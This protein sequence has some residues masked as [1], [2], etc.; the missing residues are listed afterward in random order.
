MLLLILWRLVTA[1]SIL[2]G[3]YML[4][5]GAVALFGFKK[6][7]AVPRTAPKTKFA[8]VVAARNE[9]AVIANLVHSLRRQNYPPELFDIIVAPNNCTDD[10][11]GAAQAAGATLYAPRGEIHS[12]GDVLREVVDHVV[13]AG[14]YDAMCVFDA[15]NL[16]HPDFLARMND[17]VCAGHVAVQGFRDSKNPEQSAISGCY[18]ICYWMLNRFYNSARSALGLSALVNGSGFTAT[19]EAVIYDEQPLTFR[20]SWRQRRRWTTGSLQGLQVYGGLLF[21]ETVLRRSAVC[22]DMTMTFL[23]PF[24]QLASTVLGIAGAALVLAGHGV[25]GRG[26]RG[27]RAGHLVCRRADG[28]AEKGQPARCD[29]GRGHLLAVC[30]EPYGP[31]PAELCKKRAHLAPHCPHQHR[32]H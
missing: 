10:T 13:L 21:R 4:Y 2:L 17:A 6:R 31:H 12:K 32:P 30:A 14:G 3:L 19:A 16:V 29:K 1:C 8:C 25:A 24:V 28:G 23:T 9:E 7:R 27:H 20:Q 11:A 26:R 15:D 22:F 5:F 18:S